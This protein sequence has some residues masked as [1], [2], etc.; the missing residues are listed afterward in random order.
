MEQ[1]EHYEERWNWRLKGGDEEPVVSGQ[2]H[3]QGPW[4]AAAKSCVSVYRFSAQGGVHGW[5]ILP[6]E[7]TV[8]SLFR[9]AAGNHVGVQEVC[10]TGPASHC[11][12]RS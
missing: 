10:T 12:Q 6:L 11:L 1:L 8:I 9:A 3:Y 5:L 2:L 7:N 4:Q